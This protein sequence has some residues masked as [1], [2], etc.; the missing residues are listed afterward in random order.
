MK[1]CL[2]RSPTP[3]LLKVIP[4]QNLTLTVTINVAITGTGEN[5]HQ[6]V[7]RPT[8]GIFMA[9][10]VNLFYVK[11]TEDIHYNSGM[12]IATTLHVH[13]MDNV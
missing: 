4:K 8:G 1:S 7:L 13:N 9:I 12:N 3:P 2:L 10:T 11:F 5:W 6:S